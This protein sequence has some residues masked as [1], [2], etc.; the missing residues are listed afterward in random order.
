[1][2]IWPIWLKLLCIEFRDI[3]KRIDIYDPSIIMNMSVPA[4]APEAVTDDCRM[5]G[6]TNIVYDVFV[7][8]MNY[9][10]PE[11]VRRMRTRKY[12]MDRFFITF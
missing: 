8:I 6:E 3:P 4:M 10:H 5:C 2:A 9:E 7:D 11:K 1:M 12:Y